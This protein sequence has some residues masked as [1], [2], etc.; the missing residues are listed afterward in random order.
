MS[1]QTRP[2]PTDDVRAWL[3]GRGINPTSQRVEIAHAFFSRCVHLSAED[4]FQLVNAERPRVSKA[5]V[6][7]TLAL[8]VK[9]GLIREVVA[10]PTKIVYDSNTTPHHHFYDVET[11]ELMDIDT[12]DLEVSGLPVLPSR[13]TLEGI[14]V[15]VRVRRKR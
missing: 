15:V 9:K 13:A 12:V 5:T 11:G 7:N 10:D 8:F 6:Y 2:Y 3:R 1:M 14:D 4:V